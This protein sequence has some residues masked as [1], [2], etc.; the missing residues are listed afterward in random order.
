M[1]SGHEA[2]VE[3]AACIDCHQNLDEDYLASQS[4]A[5]GESI[6]TANLRLQ[7]LET[8][9]ENVRAQ[10]QNAS[11]VRLVQGVIVGLAF[12]AAIA[13]IGFRL[14]PGRIKGDE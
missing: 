11:A 12:G 1:P 9:V 5:D 14:R 8:E 4:E 7:E 13:F 3:T 10:G 6:L 2:N